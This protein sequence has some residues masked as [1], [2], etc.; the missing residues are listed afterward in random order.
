MVRGYAVLAVLAGL[1]AGCAHPTGYVDLHAV[2][3]P[4]GGES[5]RQAMP[6]QPLRV[7]R[8]LSAKNGVLDVRVESLEIATGAARRDIYG[9]KTYAVW[10]WYAPLAKPFVGVLLIPPFYLAAHD[11]HTH[12]AENWTR[13]DYFR[14]VIAWYNLFSAMPNGPREMELTET[15]LRSETLETTLRQRRVPI[16]GRTI[17]VQLDDR[18]LGRGVSDADG[19]VSFNLAPALTA[20]LA[21]A[22]HTVRLVSPGADGETAELSWTLEAATV[23]QFLNRPP[24]P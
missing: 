23:R 20:E 5:V 3:T 10:R 24:A 12:G 11:P 4:T 1:L 7:T 14:D 2:V 16:A 22:D 18:E 13:G 15:P 9:R 6:E 19:A 21:R 8:D 17:I